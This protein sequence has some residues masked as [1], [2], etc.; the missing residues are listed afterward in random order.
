MLVAAASKLLDGV[1]AIRCAAVEPVQVATVGALGPPGRVEG[2][3]HIVVDAVVLSVL[4]PFNE[5]G[6]ARHAFDVVELPAGLGRAAG[7]GGDR[8]GGAVMHLAHHPAR[9]ARGPSRCVEGQAPVSVRRPAQRQHRKVGVVLFEPQA[10]ADEAGRANLGE[11]RARVN[12]EQARRADGR[13][14]HAGRLHGGVAV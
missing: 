8:H 4:V 1:Q 14:R 12:I 13:N 3:A 11:T 5:E 9:R 10:L 6:R 7:E 2:A